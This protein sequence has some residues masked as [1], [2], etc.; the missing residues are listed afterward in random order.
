MEK[1]DLPD[2][3]SSDDDKDY[4]TLENIEEVFDLVAAD[5]TNPLRTENQE[6]DPAPT[7]ASTAQVDPAVAE[8]QDPINPLP[9]V[10]QPSPTD[11]LGAQGVTETEEE[12]KRRVKAGRKALA[13]ETEEE[14]K[15]QEEKKERKR[16]AE[17][18]KR[19]QLEEIAARKEAER[20]KAEAD[21]KARAERHRLRTE[22][23]NAELAARSEENRRKLQENDQFI[24]QLSQ[25]IPSAVLAVVAPTSATSPV[26]MSVD[27][28]N[29]SGSAP[30]AA[31]E[32]PTSSR[33]SY[34]MIQEQ[35]RELE[36]FSGEPNKI[37]WDT[38]EYR[39][40]NALDVAP[41][42]DE[43]MKL[44][45][46]RQKLTGA[47]AELLRMDH[48]LREQGF[49]ELMAWLAYRYRAMSI[50]Q[51]EQRQ[52]MHGDTPDTYLVRIQRH[53]E[54][55]LPPLPAKKI[56][57]KDVATNLPKKDAN[58]KT[59]MIDNPEYQ[60]RLAKRQEFRKEYDGRLRR[61]YLDGLK[62]SIARKIP[63]PPQ[64]FEDLHTLVRK[65]YVHELRHP[66][67]GDNDLPTPKPQTGLAMFATETKVTPKLEKNPDE[68]PI[69][70]MRKAL[71]NM[72]DLT[73]CLTKAMVRMTENGSVKPT[74][75][76]GTAR[77]PE[78]STGVR[79]CFECGD[80]EH[81]VRE[82]P[83]RK[84][85]LQREYQQ[86][87]P[88][89]MQQRPQGTSRVQ[90][91]RNGGN[92][93]S[94]RGR[95]NQGNGSNRQQGGNQQRNN[96]GQNRNDNRGG[97]GRTSNPRGAAGK[98]GQAQKQPK[99]TSKKSNTPADR[100]QELIANVATILEQLNVEWDFEEEADQSKN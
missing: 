80:P 75:R 36:A 37:S 47:P 11:P 14:R 94:G 67:L 84:K 39:F 38:F 17:E 40:L 9:S 86:G 64:A 3:S 54:S 25:V 23:E 73:T 96:Q 51:K 48:T 59:I 65:I 92:N 35:L 50:P 6:E 20:L 43:K 79:A 71:S 2:Y 1:Q 12:K 46:L 70:E 60:E 58:G 32:K 49:D 34:N 56:A 44:S 10:L 90:F 88:K 21:S 78:S 91:Q 24:Q 27:D 28:V 93:R 61:D 77:D 55:D 85:R 33:T 87:S 68:K 74:A 100:K 29:A 69:T 52:W 19:K 72:K 95:S 26:T 53:V 97:R 63:D 18:K 7:P 31:G 13:P 57:D 99:D 22:K 45:L 83:T 15:E 62:P 5:L 82:C 89:S 66:Q 41:D 16:K 8:P 76:A 30:A 42:L 81:L 4:K 98:S